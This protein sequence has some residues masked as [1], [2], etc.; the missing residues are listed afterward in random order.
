MFNGEWAV[1]DELKNGETGIKEV[2][3]ETVEIFF[4]Q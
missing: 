2:K 4:V 1:E 3:Q